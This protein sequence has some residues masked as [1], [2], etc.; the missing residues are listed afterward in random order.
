VRGVSKLLKAL[1]VG[2]AVIVG[3]LVIGFFVIRQGPIPYATLEARY[4]T[5]S[6][7]YLD[8][9]GGVHVHYRDEGRKDAP[10][11]VLIHGFS[12]STATWDRWVSALG[13]D[14]RIVSLD[15]PGHGLTRAPATYVASS[16]AYDAIVDQTTRKLGI[17]H[18]ALAGNSMGGGVA[19]RYALAHPE[20]LTA[21]ILVDAAGW[22]ETGARRDPPLAFKLL[23]TGFGRWLLR[24]IDLK[25]LIRDGLKKAF[26]DPSKADSAMVDRFSDLSHAPDHP[27]IISNMQ[28]GQRTYADASQLATIKTPTL[29]MHGD[30]DRLIPVEHGRKFAEAIPGAQ[31][32]VYPN[33]GH[34]PQMEIAERSAADLKAFLRAHGG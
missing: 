22:P 31:L 1:G 19:W 21:L 30:H 23:R 25:P 8:L 3:L 9:P 10:V 7:R 18:F 24:Q 20:R 34:L 26:Y 12:D 6:S 11:I 15:L 33:V 14:Y 28:D 2:L 16:A 32:I 4:A 5:P 29:V 17:D 13:Q 27:A